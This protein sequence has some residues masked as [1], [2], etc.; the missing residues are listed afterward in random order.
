[1]DRNNKN[2]PVQKEFRER[3]AVKLILGVSFSAMWMGASNGLVPFP[4]L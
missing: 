2:A 4:D 3:E 1:M